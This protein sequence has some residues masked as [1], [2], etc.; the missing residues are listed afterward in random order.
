MN[1][2]TGRLLNRFARLQSSQ[3]PPN[4]RR[5]RSLSAL[6]LIEAPLAHP[7]NRR[8]SAL[9]PADMSLRPPPS[10]RRNLLLFLIFFP[11]RETN[12]VCDGN[13]SQSIAILYFVHT[14]TSSSIRSACYR[15]QSGPIVY[16]RL[17]S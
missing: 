5:A 6:A 10:D 8:R 2:I 7:E 9:Q 15:I 13:A 17:F 3:S 1:A 11:T 14:S 4:K 16:T 12:A